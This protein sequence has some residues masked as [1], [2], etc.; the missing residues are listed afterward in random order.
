MAGAPLWLDVLIFGSLGLLAV[1]FFWRARE[2]HLFRIAGLAGVGAFWL[3][4]A[5]IYVE[6][7]SDAVNIT[8]A[9]LAF[10]FFVYLAWHEWVS[11]RRD[12]DPDA[13][14]WA[15]GVTLVAGALYFSVDR[16]ELVAAALILVVAWQSLGLLQVFGYGAG[17]TV[18]DVVP[19]QG[20]LASPIYGS[21]VSIILACTAFEAI[22]IFL[23]AVYAT[24]MRADPWE[25]FNVANPARVDRLRKMG[26]DRRKLYALLLTVPVIWVLNL[27]RNAG[28][29]FLY[30]EH[31]L[32]AQAAALGMTGFEFA[33]VVLGKGLSFV[34]LV[35]IAF[36]LFRTCP[37]ILDNINGLMDLPRRGSGGKGGSGDNGRKEPKGARGSSK[38][39]NLKEPAAE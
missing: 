5:W 9:G 3:V 8:F 15:T 35:A 14:R 4:R 29:I 24:R 27:V 37:E 13:L 39:R 21:G 19:F 32:D 16:I 11:Y 2:R 7:S 33:H 38:A 22:A 36:V 1:G 18:G 20:E 31:T 6:E 25:G 34:A 28:V 23:G 17:W 10:P 30:N 26:A 12:E